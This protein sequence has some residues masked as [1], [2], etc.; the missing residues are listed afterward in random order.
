MKAALACDS[1]LISGARSVLA[2]I[3]PPDAPMGLTDPKL[4]I[5]VTS[6]EA[7]HASVL[8]PTLEPCTAPVD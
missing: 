8:K 7:H 2:D 6:V 4:A 1:S 5:A 3:G